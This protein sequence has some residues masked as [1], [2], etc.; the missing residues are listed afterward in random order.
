MILRLLEYSLLLQVTLTTFTTQKNSKKKMKMAK[1]HVTLEHT[2]L[3][4]SKCNAS[5]LIGSSTKTTSKTESD[6]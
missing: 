5:E 6:S 1:T 4:Q 3:L 2:R